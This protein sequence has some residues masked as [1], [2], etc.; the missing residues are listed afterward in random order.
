MVSLNQIQQLSEHDRVTIKVSVNDVQTSKG[1][2]AKQEVLVADSTGK[3][4]VTLMLTS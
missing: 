3:A 4:R 1:G 2:K